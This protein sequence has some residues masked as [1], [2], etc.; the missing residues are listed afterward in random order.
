LTVNLAVS[1]DPMHNLS[2][3]GIVVDLLA[4]P[5]RPVDPGSGFTEI[6][7]QTPTQFLGKGATL[8]TEDA[9]PFASG[10]AWAWNGSATAAA[11]VLEV[12]AAPVVAPPITPSPGTPADPVEALVRRF[13]PVLFFHPQ[14]M[15]FPVDAKRYVENAALWASRAPFENKNGWGGMPGDPFLRQPLVAP[16]QLAAM[17]DEPGT[18]LGTPSFLVDGE[19]DERFL[20]LGG[21]KDKTEAHEPDVTDT[22]TNVYAD[23]NAIFTRYQGCR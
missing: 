3:G 19:R 8:Q 22:S 21:W 6:D 11:I 12:K 17:P 10:V 15:L 13:A 23:R 20:E 1:A 7:E 16:G 4:N 5:A 14:E 2:A 9:A 18:Y